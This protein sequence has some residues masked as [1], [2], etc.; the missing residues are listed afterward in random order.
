MI[1]GIVSPAYY[2]TDPNNCPTEYQA[3]TCG[4]SDVVC[5]YSGG[6]TFCYD[7]S[8]INPPTV[9]RTTQTTNYG[10][11]DSSCD[12]GFIIDCHYYD[13]SEPHCDNGNTGFCDRASSCYNV[14]RITSCTANSFTTYSCST[15]RSGYTYCDGSYTD[16]DG[17]EIQI[18]VTSCSGG[19]NNNV[20]ASCNCDCDS[21]WYDC[22]SSGT[23]VGNGCEAYRT[24]SCSV[25]ALS[26]TWS[27][28]A[29][30]GGCYDT[31]G[32]TEYDCTCVVDKSYFETGTEALYS[33]S[34]S[35]S[36]LWGTDY[37]SGLLINISW[38]DSV[39]FF[40]NRTG[41]YFNGTLLGSGGADTTC[42]AD[43]SCANILYE[44]DLPLTNRVVSHWN[45]ITNT[46]SF[47]YESDLPLENRTLISWLN[48]TNI[49][50]D[51]FDGDNDTT[52]SALSEFSNDVGFVT[53]NTMNKTV[54]CSDIE[55]S[56][57]VDFCTDAVGGGNPFDQELNTTEDVLFNNVNTTDIFI[58]GR[59]KL[60][61]TDCSSLQSG[62]VC[63]N[64][65]GVYIAG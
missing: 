14:G 24:G 9:D 54:S 31:N 63:K 19:A 64:S 53:N 33:T 36:F 44:S 7:P 35:D 48:I 40:V 26:G 21:G 43:Q 57:D 13:G 47:L 50:L 1:I 6:T 25:G 38:S 27:C 52:Y 10:C 4:G 51:I 23:D 20:D 15:C 12:G 30:A 61:I 62:E 8:G 55:G 59:I 5:G 46:P 41:A 2:V 37:G 3:Q 18:G 34:A 32:G 39:G 42:E 22:D 58:F 17:C 49:P 60:Q 29:G 11:S 45:N 16:G 65:T 28:S 56:P